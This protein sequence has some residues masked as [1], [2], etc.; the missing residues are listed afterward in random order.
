VLVCVKLYALDGALPIIR[1]LVSSE[2]VVVSLQNGV[3]SV[4]SIAGVVDGAR[5]AG[6]IAY[7]SSSVE[8]DGMITHKALHRMVVGELDRRNSPRLQALVDAGKSAGF[9]AMLSPD[10]QIDIW[11]KF[12]RLSAWSGL[13]AITRS[14][15]GVVREEPELRAMLRD[16][17]QETFAVGRASAIN[18]PDAIV[19][20]TMA[21]FDALPPSAK[22]SMLDDLEQGRPLEL[23]WLSGAVVRI[24]REH[25]VQTP[26]HRFVAAALGPVVRGSAAH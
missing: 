15:I 20:D 11:T 9:D 23:P 4:R 21:F 18:L 1:S 26:T 17:V 14:P 8:D 5:V 7:L 2:S 10:I 19:D 12:V 3:E 24:G 22:S 6:G 25:G 16:A 13:T